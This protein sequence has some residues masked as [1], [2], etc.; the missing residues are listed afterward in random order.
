MIRYF[1]LKMYL[2]LLFSIPVVS[3]NAITYIDKDSLKLDPFVRYGKLDNGFTYYIRHN[4]EP[5]NE[6]YIQMVVKAGKL[7]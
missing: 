1:I 2:I 3:Q 7:P 5:K 6:V 4:N